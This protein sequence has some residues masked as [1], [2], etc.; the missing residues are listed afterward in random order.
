VSDIIDGQH[1]QQSPAHSHH[2]PQ[3]RPIIGARFIHPSRRLAYH[4]PP[5]ATPCPSKMR[6]LAMTATMG[7]WQRAGDDSPYHAHEAPAVAKPRLRPVQ[8][9]VHDSWRLAGS[10]A[11]L[12]HLAQWRGQPRCKIPTPTPAPTPA[13][14]ST[15]RSCPLGNPTARWA[16]R[17][18]AALASTPPDGDN[19]AL[20]WGR[21]C[22]ASGGVDHH[23]CSRLPWLSTTGT[24][25]GGGEGG[26]MPGG[27]G[28]GGGG[29]HAGVLCPWKYLLWIRRA[30]TKNMVS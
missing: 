29:G 28:R 1:K 3:P 6:S 18:R 14:K 8:V 25:Q 16:A 5:G 12:F 4:A 13:P 27:R 15:A 7:L 22:P 20:G 17:S 23:L 26:A 21:L 19:G 9:L 30:S 2:N 10:D 24:A 11:G